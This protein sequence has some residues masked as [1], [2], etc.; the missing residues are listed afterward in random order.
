MHP[1]AD[2][3]SRRR[4]SRRSR[5]RSRRSRRSRSRSRSRRS[6]T[7]SS[8]IVHNPIMNQPRPT[9]CWEDFTPTNLHVQVPPRATGARTG[10]HGPW[11][12]IRAF[13]GSVRLDP[14]K[15]QRETLQGPLLRRKCFC[16]SIL[17]HSCRLLISTPPPLKR[18]F[19]SNGGVY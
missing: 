1:P 7:R 4:R 10:P 5:S 9:A 19:N 6:R 18:T 3:S 2:R 11:K 13:S 12:S 8:H 15:L 17:I 14:P 16:G